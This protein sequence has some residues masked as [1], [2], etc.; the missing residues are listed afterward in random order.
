MEENNFDE[1]MFEHGYTLEKLAMFEEKYKI[2]INIY[3]I[4][5]NGPKETKQYYCSIYNGDPNIEKKVDL[6]ISRDVKDQHFVLV[7]K[8]S[9]IITESYH[10][11]HGHVK[12][13]RD[14]GTVCSTTEQLL[15]H[16]KEEHKDEAEKKQKIVLPSR[17][18]AWVNFD[19]PGSGFP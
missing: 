8:L 9:V 2:S 5:K 3:D 18:D 7:K 10:K 15:R 6:G 12:M 17:E 13:C 1:K 16:Y 11:L 4:G 19:M 14:C